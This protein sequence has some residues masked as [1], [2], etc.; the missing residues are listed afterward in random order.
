MRPPLGRPYRPRDHPRSA[1]LSSTGGDGGAIDG[2][3]TLSFGLLADGR[4]DAAEVLVDVA[5]E[6]AGH[7]TGAHRR[8]AGE[9]RAAAIEGRVVDGAQ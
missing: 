2:P 9:H 5:R 8:G 4:P 7:L 1:G 3:P 6:D